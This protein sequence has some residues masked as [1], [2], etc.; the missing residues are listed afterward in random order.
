[1]NKAFVREVDEPEPRCPGCGTL[2]QSVGRATFEAHLPPEAALAL[3]HA[4]SYC[5]NPRCGVA[6]YDA[7]GQY[8]PVEL[9]RWPA[10]PTDATAPI[11][12]CFGLTPE[13]VEADARAGVNAGVKALIAKAASPA[14]RCTMT[15]PDGRCCVDEVQKLFLRHHAKGRAAR[16]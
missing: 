12:N 13:Q 8:A 6:Y 3:T 5:P 9:L 2:G 15:M 14:A 7:A 4:V 10:Y 16:R 1:M 11:C